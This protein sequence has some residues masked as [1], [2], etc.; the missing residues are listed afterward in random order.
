MLNK[1]CIS[2]KGSISIAHL[3][4]DEKVFDAC[5]TRQQDVTGVT[6]RVRQHLVD[7]LRQ[8]ARLLAVLVRQTGVLTE[9]LLVR[10]LV[11]LETR[12]VLQL[13]PRVQLH[14]TESGHSEDTVP[15][16]LYHTVPHTVPHTVR[17]LSGHCTTHSRD[18]VRTLYHTQS[19]HCIRHNQD[20]A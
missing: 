8:H 20:I 12:D 9:L 15:R 16:I 4:D 13:L 5:A 14:H 10:V 2:V 11:D 1:S 19:G 6:H 18:I 3:V 17:T 7:V